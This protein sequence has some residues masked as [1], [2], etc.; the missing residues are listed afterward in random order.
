L[1]T[2]EVVLEEEGFKGFEG[3]VDGEIGTHERREVVLEVEI[4]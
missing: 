4:S 1:A 2:D 3:C